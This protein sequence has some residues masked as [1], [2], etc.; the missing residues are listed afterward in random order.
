MVPVMSRREIIVF[1]LLVTIGMS[2]TVSFGLWWFEPQH[3]PNNYH[4]IQHGADLL[5]FALLTFVVWHQIVG[6]LFTWNAAKDMKHPATMKPKHGLRVA[7]L[8]AF[9]P[10]KE[11]Y[12]VL[13][14]ALRSMVAADYPHD[15]WILD[16]G[17]DDQAKQLAEKYGVKY[18]TRHG[19]KRYNQAKTRYEAKT[20]GGNLNSWYDK[21]SHNYDFVAQ[22][23][24]D[25]VLSKDFL[26][27]KLGYF[28]DP[29]VAFVS[30][31]QIYSN[32]SVS[33]IAAGASEQAYSF[34]GPIQ[35]GLFGKGM[36]LPI[37][38]HHIMRVAAMDSINGYACHIAED[39]LTGMVIYAER[40][41]KSVYVPEALAA[42]EGPAN[43]AAYFGQ[44]KR[45]AYGLMHILFQYSPSLLPK[46]KRQHAL[47]YFVLQL[48][49]FY[50]LTQVIGIIL[51]SLY[52]IW[53][54]RSTNMNLGLM[55]LA[56]L[57]LLGW[58]YIIS[59]WLQRFNINP[60]REKGALIKGKIVNLAAWPVYFMAFGEYIIGKRVSYTVTPKGEQ[61]SD[62]PL[63]LFLPHF[64]LG[65]VSA[66]DI[67]LSIYWH[68]QSL[69]LLGWAIVNTAVM[70]AFVAYAVVA[71]LVSMLKKRVPV[72]FASK[73]A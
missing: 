54:V 25:F 52:F 68:H 8:T 41:W 42:G 31:P 20:K 39:H 22:M 19:S 60:E 28:N 16:E 35:K 7:F 49:Y 37:G 13:E 50:G 3:I 48:H 32:G 63:K 27:K 55:F 29:D 15:T 1:G 9:V 69:A 59:L 43:W 10:G 23:D 65:T 40:R 51:M 12:D 57:V 53:G 11:P 66:T 5:L 64:I 6:E 56:Y 61:N 46:M 36:L 38:S 26:T 18:H 58:Q 71:N 72:S 47:N 73:S 4:G 45:W 21:Y 33:W 17:N 70:Y 2:M 14:N 24:N 30:S 62:V 34:Y 44:Q 67:I